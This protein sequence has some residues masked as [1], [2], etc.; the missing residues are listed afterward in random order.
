MKIILDKTNYKEKPNSF[1][2]TKIQTRL[3]EIK[4][5]SITIEELFEAIKHGNTIVPAVMNGS[6]RKENFIEQQLIMLDIDNHDDNSKI[7]TLEDTLETLK[8]ADLEVL[9]YYYT[10]NSTPKNPSFRILLMLDKPIENINKIEFIL[11]ILINLT[12]ADHACK[13]CSRIFFGTNG[14]EKEVTL[15]NKEAT[16]TFEQVE[17]LYTQPNDNEDIDLNSEL[18]SLIN[19]FDLLEYIKK[20]AEVT[21]EN[22]NIVYFEKTCPICSHNNC[23]R[24]F[25]DTNTFRCFGANGAISGNIITFIQLVDKKSK[26]EAV[27]YFKYELLKMPREDKNY[28]LQQTN[29]DVVTQQLKS[30]GLQANVL[31][32]I[33]WI[34]TE[35]KNNMLVVKICC[36]VLAEFIRNHMDYIF[37]RNNAKSGIMRYIY[38][39]G[40]YKLSNDD[41]FKGL[42]KSLIPLEYQ[43][44]SDITEV[45]NL[46]YTDFKFVSMEQLNQDENIINFNNG[47][48]H[49]DTMELK[50][51]TPNYLSTIRIPCNYVENPEKPKNN[52]FDNYLNDLTGSNEEIKQLLLEFIGVALSNIKGYRMKKALF[53]IGPPNS[54]KSKIKEFTQQMIG[55]ENCSNIE[56][57]DFELQFGK[58]SLFGKRLVG[59]TDLSYM[60]VKELN[61]FKQ[62]T[63]GDRINAE[64][65][66]ENMFDFI[67]NGVLWFCG[68][69]LPK[70]SGDKG[71]HVYERIVIIES[72]SSIPVEKQDNKLLDHLLEEKEYIVSLA[73]KALKRVINNGYRYDIPDVCKKLTEEYQVNNDSFLKFYDEC[74]IERKP[75]L[76]IKDFCTCGKIYEV[77]R[78]YCRDNNNSYCNKKSEVK[79]ILTKMGKEERISSM[80]H[81]EYYKYLTLK[82]EVIKEYEVVFGGVSDQE[83]EKYSDDINYDNNY[84]LELN[85]DDELPF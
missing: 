37:V 77:Y 13:N 73:V 14:D 48:L 39:D 32:D 8:N 33:H 66:H 43:K 70:F 3:K 71:D 51:H 84:N 60:S 36:P 42:I 4:P 65:K 55:P 24:Y 19:N 49:L 12:H 75:N 16:I 63:G 27:E 46:L 68:N 41:E 69:Q 23:F 17:K 28:E 22:G 35:Y 15:L 18:F 5:S 54:G 81:N 82:P 31:S 29:L 58:S 11:E 40:Y 79:E 25:K 59:S 38:K 67:F 78:L 26:K 72:N 45:L 21:G 7:I 76:K 64:F 1:E 47:I 74:I 34:R 10:F 57:K 52:Y 30:N 6:I 85:L 56:L 20:Y 83:I 9:G 61:I 50:P 44:M 53:L 2:I 62:A 80:N